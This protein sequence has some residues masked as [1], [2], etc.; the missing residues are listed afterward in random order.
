MGRRGGACVVDASLFIGFA[1]SLRGEHNGITMSASLSSSFSLAAA[2]PGWPS[3]MVSAP[4]AVDPGIPPQFHTVESHQR[5]EIGSSSGDLAIDD[6][7][8]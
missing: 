4:T 3:G 2:A 5:L 8:L 7:N 1:V 6:T